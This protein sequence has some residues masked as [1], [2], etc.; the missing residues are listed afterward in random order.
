MIERHS[1][2][3]IVREAEPEGKKEG[4]ERGANELVV[5]KENPTQSQTD[6]QIRRE[7]EFRESMGGGEIIFFERRYWLFN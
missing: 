1:Q 2:R 5:T 7:R 3:D 6:N 4:R